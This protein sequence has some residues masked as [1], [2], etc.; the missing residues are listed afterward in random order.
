M[1]RKKQSSLP[2]HFM[3][4]IPGLMEKDHDM[5]NENFMPCKTDTKIPAYL[6]LPRFI[7]YHKEVSLPD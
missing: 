6:P 3:C 7:F 4:S 2:V 1:G 5:Q